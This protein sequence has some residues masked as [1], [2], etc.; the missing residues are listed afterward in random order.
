MTATASNRRRGSREQPRLRAAV[1]THTLALGGSPRSLLNVAGA[2]RLR[3]FTPMLYYGTPGPLETEF[4]AAN[5]PSRHLPKY[6]GLWGLHLGFIYRIMRRYRRDNIRLVFLNCLVSY[7]KYHAL[8]ARLLGLPIIW[9]IREDVHSKRGRRL[10]RWLRRLADIVMPC[11]SAI[12]NTLRQRGLDLPIEV[13]H[14]GIDV[15]PLDDTD[16]ADLRRRL[17]IPADRWVVGC[18]GS[19]EVRKGQLDLV[20]AL[21]G[22]TCQDGALDL[23]LVGAPGRK[24]DADPYLLDLQHT[25]DRLPGHVRVHLIGAHRDI[26]PLY[27]EMDVVCLPSHWEG[28]SRTILEAMRAQ[29]P[30][31]TT[32]AGG[33]PEIVR[34][35]ESAY[36]V[37]P[38]DRHALV[39]GLRYLK[40]HP[41]K[42][43]ALAQIAHRDLCADYTLSHYRERVAAV[44]DAALS[45]CNRR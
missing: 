43:A 39:E 40:R 24:G 15:P 2:V 3:G 16:D 18:V 32:T 10:F 34:H 5:I 4:S 12:A 17:H 22:W 13:V 29:R 35:M 38:G 20:A 11:S 44:I 26:A 6:K 25:V 1:V 23:V 41:R 8:A 30:L 36:L 31:L 27:K 45:S 19:I 14:N 37:S 21:N 42:A 33:N 9:S 28:S 7:Y